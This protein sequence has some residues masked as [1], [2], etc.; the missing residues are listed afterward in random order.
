VAGGLSDMSTKTAE[1]PTVPEL[2]LY[3]FEGTWFEVARLPLPIPLGADW[4]NTSDTYTRLDEQRWRVI[5]RGNKGSS[6]G[7]ER[8]LRQRLR[9][10]DPTQPGEMQ[11]SFLWPVWLPYR[12]IYVS[13]DYHYMLVT[14]SSMRLLWVMS[15]EPVPPDHEYDR[16]VAMASEYGFDTESLYRVPQEAT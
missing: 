8:S 7:P 2:D 5:Y 3:R 14:S 11:V 4:V 1:I 12:L 15:R 16:L 10:P 6:N 13:Q 9:V